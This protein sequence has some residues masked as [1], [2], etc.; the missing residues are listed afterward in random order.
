MSSAPH[1]GKL[2]FSKRAQNRA[3]HN[4]IPLQSLGAGLPA[5]SSMERKALHWRSPNILFPSGL[6]TV[7]FSHI[8]SA[9]KRRQECGVS[10]SDSPVPFICLVGICPLFRLKG[11]R[12]I[13]V[14]DKQP[15]IPFKVG[16]WRLEYARLALISVGGWV[17]LGWGGQDIKE[18]NAWEAEDA[19][20]P[21]PP[22]PT[23]PT[24]IL[25]R[26]HRP[27]IHSSTAWCPL[28]PPLANPL[29]PSSFVA[30]LRPALPPS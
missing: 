19:P 27:P 25:L 3:E 18:K 15:A 5:G 10:L 7:L 24:L 1:N 21:P 16:V 6:D 11:P 8:F 4:S 2:C 12:L 9:I 22:S 28:P 23:Y 14:N 26:A 20:P 17:G 29:H 13:V 30:L